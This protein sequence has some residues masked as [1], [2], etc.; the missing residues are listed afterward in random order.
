MDVAPVSQL[1]YGGGYAAF[2]SVIKWR[3]GKGLAWK[4]VE[5]EKLVDEAFEFT[6]NIRDLPKELLLRTKQTL[7]AAGGTNNHDE[8]LQRETAEQVWSIQQPFARDSIAAMMA[9]ISSK[10]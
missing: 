6:K 10:R 4:C 7:R 9:K 5:A 1:E 3:R 8:I 2:L